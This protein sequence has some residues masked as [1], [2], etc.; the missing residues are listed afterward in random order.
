MR[1]IDGASCSVLTSLE[2]FEMANGQ[3]S[4]EKHDVLRGYDLLAQGTYYLYVGFWKLHLLSKV[5]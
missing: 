4:A 1:G 3:K 2:E 5:L